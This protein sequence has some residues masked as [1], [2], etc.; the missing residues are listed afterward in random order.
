MKDVGVLWVVV[1]L[2]AVISVQISGA[3]S[4]KSRKR[5]EGPVKPV[6][7]EKCGG[8]S[9]FRFVSHRYNNNVFLS[10]RGLGL[11]RGVDIG[12]PPVIHL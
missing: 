7:V 11:F 2:F 3:A 1:L 8:E 9:T 10:S 5:R 4:N 6:K 12:F